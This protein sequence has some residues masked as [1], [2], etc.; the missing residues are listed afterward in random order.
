MIYNYTQKTNFKLEIPN[1][2]VE[3]AVMNVQ[4]LNLPDMSIAATPF[5]I[6]PQARGYLPGSGIEF[7]P[8]QMRLIADEELLSYTDIYQWMCSVVEHKDSKATAWLQGGAPETLL[9]HILNNEKD[10]IILT[11][12]FYSPFPQILGSLEF[13]YTDPSNIALGFN[14]TFGYK[15]FEIEKDGKIMSSFKQNSSR[16]KH[17]LNR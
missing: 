2:Y 12:R 3:N 7:E 9:V 14:I 11:Y 6:N 16:G 15:Y 10:R 5:S 17:P 8:L 4:E 1:N 13:N